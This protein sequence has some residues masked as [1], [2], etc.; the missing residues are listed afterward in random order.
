M[1]F[2]PWVVFVRAAD[3]WDPMPVAVIGLA[4]FVFILWLMMAKPF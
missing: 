4:A 3:A 1:D 2:Y